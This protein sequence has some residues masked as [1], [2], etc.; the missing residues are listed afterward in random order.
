[1]PDLEIPV[2]IVFLNAYS[3]PLPSARRCYELG[4]AIRE[5]LDERT[6]RVAIY[7]SGGLSHDPN[8]PRAGWI[9]EPFDRWVLDRIA[10]G[11]WRRVLG[12]TWR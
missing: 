4:L 3:P 9:D 1:M 12:A 11:N 5:L 6:E 2:V 10:W 8:G 7:G